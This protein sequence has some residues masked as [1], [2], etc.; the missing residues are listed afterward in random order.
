[1]AKILLIDD[2]AD[3]VD[4]LIVYLEYKHHEVEVAGSGQEGLEMMAASRHDLILLDWQLP[5]M[6]GIDVCRQYRSNG[7]KIKILMLT[8]MSDFNSMQSGL[9]AGADGYLTK[10]FTV[11]QL[12]SRVASMVES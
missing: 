10:P 5:D 4:C 12:V 6:D 2:D 3:L 8:G 11:E 9:D 1:M 7:G